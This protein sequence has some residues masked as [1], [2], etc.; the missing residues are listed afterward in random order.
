VGERTLWSESRSSWRFAAW[1]AL[2]SA[3]ARAAATSA[4]AGCT[5]IGFLLSGD[6]WEYPLWALARE[7]GLRDVQVLH[8]NVRNPSARLPELP[9][10]PPCLLV[11]ADFASVTGEGQQ[12]AWL[13]PR[14]PRSIQYDGV[15]YSPA[16]AEAPLE[17]FLPG[18]PAPARAED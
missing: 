5:R 3:Y 16:W 10:P 4:Q 6:A 13:R 15:T 12:V 9:G 14:R 7:A 17:V 18:P 1:P 11:W 8:L 2:Q